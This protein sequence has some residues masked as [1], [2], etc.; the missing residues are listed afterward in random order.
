MNTML[1][2]YIKSAVGIVKWLYFI[3]LNLLGPFVKIICILLVVGGG[4]TFLFMLWAGIGRTGFDAAVAGLSVRHVMFM[5]LGMALVGMSGAIFYELTIDRMFIE[6]LYPDEET[7]DD[8]ISRLVW[9]R[10]WIGVLALLAGFSLAARYRYPALYVFEWPVIGFAW[11]L[12]IG[13]ALG[14]CR[15]LYRQGTGGVIDSI[16]TLLRDAKSVVVGSAGRHR[17]A[18][19]ADKEIGAAAKEY[20][21]ARTVVPF[22][23]R[24]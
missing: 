2:T 24:G 19:K 12:M 20:E 8:G 11:W 7:Q 16:A 22:R 9:L 3:I 4:L 15:W 14:C 17:G 18:A 23:S 10:N 13:V 21:D 1:D 5:G 6:R